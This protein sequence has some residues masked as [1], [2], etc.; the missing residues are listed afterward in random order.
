MGSPTPHPRTGGGTALQDAR[1]P[2]LSRE[3]INCSLFFYQASLEPAVVDL[4]SAT[5]PR[6]VQRLPRR[7]ARA[8]L[9]RLRRQR[10]VRRRWRRLR[11]GRLLSRPRLRGLRPEGGAA[12]ALLSRPVRDDGGDGRIRGGKELAPWQV[13]VGGGEGGGA[14]W[15]NVAAGKVRQHGWRDG[16][17]RRAGLWRRRPKGRAWLLPA[18][19]LPRRDGRQRRGGASGC[20]SGRRRTSDRRRSEANRLHVRLDTPVPLPRQRAG[21]RAREGGRDRRRLRLLLVLLRCRRSGGKCGGRARRRASGRHGGGADSAGQGTERRRRGGRRLVRCVCQRQH[22]DE[23]ARQRSGRRHGA[24][25][26]ARRDRRPDKHGRRRPPRVRAGGIRP[27]RGR[28]LRIGRR[29][30]RPRRG[31]RR[32]VAG[33]KRGGEQPGRQHR[34]HVGSLDGCQGADHAAAAAAARRGRILSLGRGGLARRRAHRCR[35]AHALH[36]AAAAAPRCG[37][38]NPLRVTCARLYICVRGVDPEL[39]KSGDATHFATDGPA[40]RR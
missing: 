7:A 39:S 24:E 2:L 28:P 34:L 3:G 13:R 37:A 38:H 4:S 36:A 21:Q 10:R 6:H 33:C 25:A 16:R 26:G 8:G 1:G 40:P 5:L 9:H 35:P 29:Q 20:C 27:G 32:L 11:L 17:L 14:R 31:R 19:L 12:G 18:H 30:C 22:G 15:R 23:C